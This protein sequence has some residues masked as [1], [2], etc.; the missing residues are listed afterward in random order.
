MRINRPKSRT[1]QLILRAIW[2]TENGMTRTEIARAIDRKKSPHLNNII[3]GLVSDGI[4][5]RRVVTFHNGV[6]GYEYSLSEDYQSH[7]LE[8]LLNQ[9]Q[10]TR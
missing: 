7:Q 4:L 3:D 2:E 5:S 10:H 9:E 8:D 1:Q 6:E